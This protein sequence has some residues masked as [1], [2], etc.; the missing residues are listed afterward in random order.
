MLNKDAKIKGLYDE[1]D[2]VIK[3]F[4]KK[5]GMITGRQLCHTLIKIRNNWDIITGNEDK[6]ENN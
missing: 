5:N 6:V 2:F 3:E 1:V 4:H